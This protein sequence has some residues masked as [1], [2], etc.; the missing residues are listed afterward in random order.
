MALFEVFVP[1]GQTKTPLEAKVVLVASRFSWSAFLFTGLWALYHRLWLVALL[2]LLSVFVLVGLEGY[3]GGETGF[4]L[5]VAFSA[6]LGFA[7]AD[8]RAR[9][10]VMKG[11]RW[12]SVVAAHDRNDA[13]LRLLT[14]ETTR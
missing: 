6:W 5:Y 4:W 11:Y 10:L 7:A 14:E 8:L 2:W 13:L 9:K 12:R 3:L 1:Q